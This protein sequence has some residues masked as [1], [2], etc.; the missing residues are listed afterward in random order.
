[1]KESVKN[2]LN[3]LKKLGIAAAIALAIVGI[4]LI[5][6]NILAVVVPTGLCYGA[7]VLVAK[8]KTGVLNWKDGILWGALGLALGIGIVIAI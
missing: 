3:D 6:I 5:E 8:E 7:G 2:T 1:M 4:A